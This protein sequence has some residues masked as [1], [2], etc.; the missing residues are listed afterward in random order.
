MIG[1]AASG[2]W[3]ALGC[4]R[5]PIRLRTQ[6]LS[7]QHHGSNVQVGSRLLQQSLLSRTGEFYRTNDW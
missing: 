2:V 7:S 6:G 1:E 5:S 3:D 4:G